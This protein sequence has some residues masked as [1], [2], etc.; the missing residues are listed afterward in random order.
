VLRGFDEVPPLAVALSPPSPSQ[1]TET[2]VNAA[3]INGVQ[4]GAR[5]ALTAFLSHFPEL[6]VE[7]DLL[8]SGY[9]A[10]LMSDEMEILW[11][12][13]HR[14][15]ESLLSRVPPLA[16]HSPPDGVREE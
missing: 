9:N 8:G 13:T 16:A 6:E 14:A 4:S 10:N 12:R 15:S 5:R 3:A 7:L 2:Q 11:T 1:L